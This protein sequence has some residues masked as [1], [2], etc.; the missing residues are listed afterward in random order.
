MKYLLFLTPFFLFNSSKNDPM[1][2]FA[3]IEILPGHLETY[4]A[5]LN[6]EAKASLEKEDGVLCIHP[7]VKGNHVRMLEVE[8]AYQAH[9]LHYKNAK[10]DRIKSLV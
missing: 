9:F 4:L 1:D 2:R 7:T 5:F 3:E 10:T 8:A 6:E